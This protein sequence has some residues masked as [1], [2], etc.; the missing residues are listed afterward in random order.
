MLWLFHV[1]RCSTIE[2]RVLI[3]LLCRGKCVWNIC[4]LVCCC[5]FLKWQSWRVFSTLKRRGNGWEM[6]S[7][8]WHSEH[9]VCYC[10]F[11]VSVVQEK[12]GVCYTIMVCNIYTTEANVWV[13]YSVVCWCGCL[14]WGGSRLL[15]RKWG[16]MGNK[17]GKIPN[18]HFPL[19]L[20]KYGRLFWLPRVVRC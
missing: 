7:M 17:C 10:G 6:Y 13:S 1:M 4:S 14:G 19:W 11:F 2:T 5:S 12:K 8:L 3:S 18:R 15:G 9:V 16:C 20:L